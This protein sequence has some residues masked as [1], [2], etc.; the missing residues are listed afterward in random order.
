MFIPWSVLSWDGYGVI[1]I[2]EN[3]VSYTSCPCRW[4]VWFYVMLLQW[5]FPGI[6]TWGWNGNGYRDIWDM[7][8]LSVTISA[9]HFSF[10]FGSRTYSPFDVAWI[11]FVFGRPRLLWLGQYALGHLAQVF[12]ASQSLQFVSRSWKCCSSICNKREATK[13]LHIIYIHSG[14]CTLLKFQLYWLLVYLLSDTVWRAY[15][16]CMVIAERRWE[17]HEN[18]YY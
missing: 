4:E 2:W 13:L 6:S 5:C 15:C 12:D 11:A 8:I 3:L 17:I 10:N 14:S 18:D 7:V 16:S 9:Q 1:Y